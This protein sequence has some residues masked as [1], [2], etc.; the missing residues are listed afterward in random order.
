VSDANTLGGLGRHD[1]ALFAIVKL[2]Y[3]DQPP[4][5]GWLQVG[6][7]D[8]YLVELFAKVGLDALQW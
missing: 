2:I 1:D 4:P 7:E 8:P 5:A 3:E 6:P